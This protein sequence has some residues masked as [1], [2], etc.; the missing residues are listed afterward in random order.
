MA[1]RDCVAPF[2]D[3]CPSRLWGR[4][5][6][7]RAGPYSESEAGGLQAAQ[8]PGPGPGRLGIWWTIPDFDLLQAGWHTPLCLVL[9]CLACKSP[10]PPGPGPTRQLADSDIRDFD[11]L[12][13][14]TT[15]CLVVQV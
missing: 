15:L 12:G 5:R 4:L 3:G 6:H 7:A 9:S 11:L 2:Y 14:H 13:W 1:A 8:S 10:G